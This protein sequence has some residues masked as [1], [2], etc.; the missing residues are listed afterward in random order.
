MRPLVVVVVDVDGVVSPVHGVTR[1]SDDVVVGNVFGPVH[2]S[3][4]LNAHLDALARVPGVQC[5]WLTSWSPEMGASMDAFPGRAWA[6]LN[7]GDTST[8]ARTWRKLEALEQWLVRH[9]TGGRGATAA[10]SPVGSVVWLDDDLRHGARKAACR[11]R[12]DALG[13]D[14]LLVV[15]RVNE[16]LTPQQMLQV[17]EWVRRRVETTDRHLLDQPW[18]GHADGGRAARLAGGAVR[19]R[20][21]RVALSALLAGDDPVRRCVAPGAHHPLPR[22]VGRVV[23]ASPQ[24]PPQIS[25]SGQVA[26]RVSMQQGHNHCGDA[27]ATGQ[28]AS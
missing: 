6:A 18:P 16:G 2:V 23:K 15:Q 7:P 27:R 28:S 1:W 19:L 13:V 11:R 9:A 25:M 26:P 3:P 20:L 10:A 17:G 4:A 8:S 24:Q 5:L 14:S 12:L 22:P 21:G